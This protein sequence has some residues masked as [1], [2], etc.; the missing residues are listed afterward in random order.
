MPRK[1]RTLLSC[2][3]V[4]ARMS[5]ATLAP[6]LPALDLSP[7]ADLREIPAAFGDLLVAIRRHLH[8]HPELGFQEHATSRFIR[9]T[10]EDHGLT[11][12]GPVAETG[13]Y[14]DIHGD[15][16]GGCVAYRADIDALPI[17]DAK[18]VSYASGIPGVAHLC[19]HDVHTTIGMGVALLL[20]RL[21]DQL[22]GTV[23]VFFQ[24]NEEGAPSGAVAMIRDG[25][26][27]GVE[28]AYAVHVDPTLEV[29]RYGLLTGAVT[30]AA[31]R[32]RIRVLSERTGH[33][34]R[35]HQ[36]K[37]TVWIAMQIMNACY[38]L[39]GRVTDARHPAVLTVCRLRAGDAYNVIPDCTE[40][41]GTIRT[42]DPDDRDYLKHYIRHTAEHIAGL[43]DA[44]VDVTLDQGAPAVIND[45]RLIAN[46]EATIHQ[47][48]GAEAVYHIPLP[49]MGSED[50]AHYLEYVP[51]ALVRIGTASGPRTQ[52]PLHDASFDIDEA[53]LAPAVQLMVGTLLNHQKRSVVRR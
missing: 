7:L 10:L 11:V 36:A 2:P 21:R 48:Y 25:I 51:G 52:H 31:D 22:A 18:Q 5:L 28:A 27:D 49:S 20:D 4:S 34:A 37:D 38:G 19:G 41:G 32:F 9:T 3:P 46:L 26:L 16:P 44:T 43:H 45:E 13:L 50:F 8:A 47:L 15:E 24:P 53:A 30:A 39:A 40:F 35:P 33:S 1:G 29:G 14:V 42:T 6:D 12:H 23:R 17:Q